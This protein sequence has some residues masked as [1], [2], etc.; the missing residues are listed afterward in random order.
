MASAAAVSADISR[1]P[2]Q[3][4][5]VAEGFAGGVKSVSP[6]PV[7]EDDDI[8]PTRRRPAAISSMFPDGDS[9]LVEDPAE[10]DD[11]DE[12][13]DDADI[14]EAALFGDDDDVADAAPA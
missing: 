2:I 7:D 10:K 9:R 4:P 5:D 14:D 13:L 3:D 8:G 12:P 6:P 11:Q 1:S